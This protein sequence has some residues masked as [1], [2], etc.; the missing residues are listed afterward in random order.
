MDNASNNN[1]T[2]DALLNYLPSFWSDQKCFCLGHIINLIIKAIIFSKN[3]SRFECELAGASDIETFEL[4]R[5]TG[6]IG[7]AHNIILYIFRSDLRMQEFMAYLIG[8]K[9]WNPDD[10]ED[11]MFTHFRGLIKDSGGKYLSLSLSFS[12]TNYYT[13]VRWNSTLCMLESFEKNCVPITTFLSNHKPRTNECTFSK[14]QDKLEDLDWDEIHCFIK[15]FK[16]FEQTTKYAEGNSERAASHGSLWEIIPILQALYD[17]L[18]KAKAKYE[19]KP[20]SYF[21]CG[22]KLGIE[23]LNTYYKEA[24]YDSPYYCAAAILHPSLN[25]P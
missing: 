8:K 1:T 19:K 24:V 4:W 14:I 6:A 25:Q 18:H 3:C 9:E 10:N 17:H 15:L 7:K 13:I 23:K 5:T 16:V 2:V 12:L 22:I 21:K 20:D 11:P